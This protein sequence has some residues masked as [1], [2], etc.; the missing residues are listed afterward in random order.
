MIEYLE[1]KISYFIENLGIKKYLKRR[2]FDYSLIAI[3]IILGLYLDWEIINVIIFAFV[4][5]QILFPL[6]RTTLA[7]ISLLL[8]VFLPVLFFFEKDD[9]A[10]KLAMLIFYILCLSMFMAIAEYL[11]YQKSLKKNEK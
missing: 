11:N 7:S 4:I 3:S 9:A 5:W 2:Y 1:K 6:S 10:E 8:I